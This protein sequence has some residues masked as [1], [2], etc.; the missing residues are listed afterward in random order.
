MAHD[1]NKH[2]RDHQLSTTTTHENSPTR[3]TVLH[4]L[5]VSISVIKQLRDD[6]I[7][8]RLHLLQCHGSCSAHETHLSL[9]IVDVSEVVGAHLRGI[10]DDLFR[11]SLGVPSDANAKA[12]AV[13]GANV[14]DQVERAREP[15]LDLLERALAGRRIATQ[16]ENV[17]NASSLCVETSTIRGA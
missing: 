8:A 6:K 7:C 5:N 1:H 14:L 17:A 16:R 12:V 13:L 9:Q 10:V 3:S 15:A 11:M 4:E 2:D